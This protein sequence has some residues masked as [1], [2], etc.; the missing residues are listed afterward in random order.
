MLGPFVKYSVFGG[1]KDVVHLVMRENEAELLVTIL[2][3]LINWIVEK[4][5]LDAF[6]EEDGLD[7]GFFLILY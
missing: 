5:N 4:L 6:Q 7:L 2:D 3:L 1:I